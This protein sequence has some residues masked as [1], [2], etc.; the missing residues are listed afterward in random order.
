MSID[1]TAQLNLFG[2]IDED[3]RIIQKYEIRKYFNQGTKA[4]QDLLNHYKYVEEHN[5]RVK[6]KRGEKC[7]I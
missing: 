6:E 7:L 1:K 4:F 5:K 2:E 3:E